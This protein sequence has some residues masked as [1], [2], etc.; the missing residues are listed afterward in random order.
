MGFDP[1]KELRPG[2]RLTAAETNAMRRQLYALG[3]PQSDG[4]IGVEQSG[5]GIQITDLKQ[6]KL[7]AR[8]TAQ[9][10]GTTPQPKYAYGWNQVID[11]GDGTYTDQPTDTSNAP[12]GTP[13]N[14]PAYEVS[15]RTD[16]PFASS[17]ATPPGPIVELFPGQQD[18]AAFYFRW[19]T[20]SGGNGP[21]VR[22][23]GSGTGVDGGTAWKGF[24]RKE[25]AGVM[26]DDVEIG[27]VSNPYVI[28]MDRAA[29]GSVGVPEINDRVIAVPDPLRA[30]RWGAIPKKVSQYECGDCGWLV[31]IGIEKCLSFRSLGGENQ[32]SCIPAETE[33]LPQWSAK[34]DTD[35]SG[36]VRYGMMTT[37]C[38]C[39][40]AILRLTPGSTLATLSIL[41]VH[42]TCAG[43]SGPLSGHA[44][45]DIPLERECCGIDQPGK[46]F[47]IY[48]GYGPDPCSGAVAGCY[49]AFRVLVRCDEDCQ[50]GPCDVCCSSNS[51]PYG[52]KF[53]PL[54]AGVFD[55]N[56]Y[57]GYW[58]MYVKPGFQGVWEGA[59]GPP[60][61]SGKTAT[62]EYLPASNKYRLTIGTA[63]YEKNASDWT[64]CG[65]NSLGYVSGYAGTHPSAIV[66]NPIG[67]NE[68]CGV[69][70]YPSTLVVSIS[71][72]SCPYLDGKNYTVTR[73][74]TSMVWTLHVG[75]PSLDVTV[76]CVDGRWHVGITTE[77]T[78]DA[79]TVAISLTTTGIPP[80][81]R[82]NPPFYLQFNAATVS[83]VLGGS[84]CCAASSTALVTVTG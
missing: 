82:T 26:V 25:V 74:G 46:R 55:D 72:A 62:L 81:V 78:G 40:L 17:T 4:H 16:V 75:S 41:G 58:T 7:L 45:V 21:I 73:V 80:D 56:T 29:D 34:W 23:T 50:A 71:D 59:C 57:D 32:C 65:S 42:V 33:G 18:K 60:S 54:A 1:P 67:G 20:G 37:C 39:G 31:G 15:R 36:W 66:V 13:T 30:G 22:L 79:G 27:P 48:L 12:W 10:D 61:G 38:G 52:W 64:C 44:I 51:A 6:S 43:G 70:V 53:G 68:S 3:R 69:C 2:E 9:G 84:S 24:I 77:C 47:A 35:L 8:L 49:N 28:Y 63:I 5:F 11:N 83:S 19:G 14:A 76:S